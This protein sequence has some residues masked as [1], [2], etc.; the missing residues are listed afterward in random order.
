M[1]SGK[2]QIGKGMWAIPD[3]IEHD[4][5]KDKSPKCWSKL[6]LGSLTNS[7][8]VTRNALSSG[9]RF[10][11]QKE[12]SKREQSNVNNML[13]IPV[14]GK[15]NWPE[16]MVNKELENNAQSILGYVVRWIDQGVGCSKSLISIILD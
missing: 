4:R 9:R 16:L 2:A 15:T 7:C 11:K 5:T 1:V 10:K 12:L 13:S 3:K 8:N 14:A 6:C